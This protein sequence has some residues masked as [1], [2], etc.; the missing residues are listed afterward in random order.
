LPEQL[1]E[2]SAPWLFGVTGDLHSNSKL[3]LCP[4]KGVCL[5]EGGTYTPGKL[6][7]WLWQQWEDYVG[8]IA[9]R[10]K[11]EGAKLACGVNGE[12]SD[13]DHHNT[14]QIITRNP[15]DMFAIATACLMPLIKLRPD[16]WL[17][18]RGTEA[19]AGKDGSFDESMARFLGAKGDPDTGAAS[20]W[21]C[22]PTFAGV[23]FH[24]THHG[25][26][27]TR[28]WTFGGA[29][30]NEAAE[31]EYEF[32]RSDWKPDIAI[33]NHHHIFRDS[34]DNHRVRVIGNLAWQL[35][36]AFAQRIAANSRLEVGGLQI[37][38]RKGTYDLRVFRRGADRPTK[39]LVFV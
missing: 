18:T 19:H 22:K 25:R 29:A 27:G 31:L 34:G 15:A 30:N 3:G 6:G 36:T 11:R 32:A 24:V 20:H 2:P 21:V 38:C 7:V 17:V 8:E 39:P 10:R 5:D 1:R 12:F 33:R 16:V 23:N 26:S 4:P 37:L 9:E 35:K 28:P 13:L 14:S